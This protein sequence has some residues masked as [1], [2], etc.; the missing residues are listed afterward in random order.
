[1]QMKM[2]TD[3]IDKNQF[4]DMKA[5]ELD[6]HE[7]MNILTLLYLKGNIEIAKNSNK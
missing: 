4:K 2:V 3:K 1:M 7:A 5:I 6:N